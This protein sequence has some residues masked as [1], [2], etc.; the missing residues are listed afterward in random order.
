MLPSREVARLSANNVDPL[1]RF[2]GPYREVMLGRMKSIY[3][4]QPPDENGILVMLFFV[5]ND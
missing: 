3:S 1:I 2:L 4:F 5:I